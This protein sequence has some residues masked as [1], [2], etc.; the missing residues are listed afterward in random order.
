MAT[1]HLEGSMSLR[2]YVTSQGATSAH[3]IF[4]CKAEDGTVFQQVGFFKDE[5]YAEGEKNKYLFL[6]LSKALSSKHKLTEDFLSSYAK[7]LRVIETTSEN[8]L[9]SA[10]MYLPG[11]GSRTSNLFDLDW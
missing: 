6:T 2:D 4:D 3:K 7:E 5:D 9:K 11:D 1:N 10:T 8:G